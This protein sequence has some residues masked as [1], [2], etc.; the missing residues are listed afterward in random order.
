MIA[1]GARENGV[2]ELL[3]PKAK[4]INLQNLKGESALTM[5]VRSGTPEA[6]ALVLNKGADGN[7]KDKDG[8][9]LGI[10]LVQSYRPA[11]REAN[12]R[13]PAGL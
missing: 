3:L 11:G 2:L 4:N 8:N 6:V 13:D 1:A 5:A 10:Y 7:V 12:S 9:N